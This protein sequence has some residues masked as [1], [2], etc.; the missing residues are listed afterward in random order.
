MNII[1]TDTGETLNFTGRFARYIPINCVPYYVFNSEQRFLIKC[2][3]YPELIG[4]LSPYDLINIEGEVVE[5]SE[6][7]IKL[8]N[9]KWEA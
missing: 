6:E 3:D 5:R 2:I 1:R 7:G 9:V 8:T 4:K